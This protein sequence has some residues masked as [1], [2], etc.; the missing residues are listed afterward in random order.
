M[1][2]VHSIQKE[3]DLDFQ[4]FSDWQPVNQYFQNS[5]DSDEIPH[6]VL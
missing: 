6:S 2:Y 5:V 3:S 4:P 1:E